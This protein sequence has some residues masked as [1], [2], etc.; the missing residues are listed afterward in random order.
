MTRLIRSEL[1]KIRTTRTVV[2]LLVLTLALVAL[3]VSLTTLDLTQRDS[4]FALGSSEG[5]R[6]VLGNVGTSGAHVIMLTLGILLLA[7]EFRHNTITATLL[8]TPRRGRVVSAKVVAIT[9]VGVV[10]GLLSIALALAI[11]MPWLSAKGAPVP[12][13]DSDVQL[14]LLGNLLVLVLFGLIGLGVGALVRNPVV[15]VAVAI[16]FFL[17]V[18]PL[19]GLVTNL[20]DALNSVGPYLPTAAAS[21]LQRSVTSAEDP[22]AAHLLP[23]WG[24]G[25]VLLGYA[26]VLCFLGTRLVVERDIT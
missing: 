21:A 17:I 20:V 25:L 8:A 26:T 24:G 12:L 18:E 19:L 10:F 6:W 1:L 22:T 5:L 3:V 15:A 23:M 16:P 4:E 14:T 9:L 2:W 13:G 11:A 7:G